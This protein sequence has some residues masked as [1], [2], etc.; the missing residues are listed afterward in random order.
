MIRRLNRAWKDRIEH[1]YHYMPGCGWMKK[2][3]DNVL[4]QVIQRSKH[5]KQLKKIQDE[6][7]YI[8]EKK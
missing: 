3:G 7:P 5:M 2:Y 8:E 4:V 6:H 1:G